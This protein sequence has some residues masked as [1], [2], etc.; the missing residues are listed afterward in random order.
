MP[1][2]YRVLLTRPKADSEA[3]AV[4][5][6]ARGIDSVIA[7]I[8]DIQPT[9]VPLN[10]PPDTQILI[11]TS[12]NAFSVMAG[13]GIDRALPVLAVGVDTAERARAYGF[14]QV[15][16][17]GGT[18]ETLIELVVERFSPTAGPLLW[19]SGEDI[20]VDLVTRLAAYGF[21]I[22]RRIVYR[23]CTARTLP[24]AA[25]NALE[26]NA[27]ESTN[28]NGVL[29]F[30]PR[31]AS[32]FVSLVEKAGLTDRTRHL[33][34]HCLSPTVAEAVSAAVWL[35]IRTALRPRRQDLLAN[36]DGHVSPNAN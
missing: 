11:V 22:V 25:I 35:D 26:V 30:S 34:A 12:G 2:P 7:P 20:R 6:A 29:F 31:T 9:G 18:A 23:A 16:S 4:E 3:L 36:L 13:H 17:V 32:C 14:T 1:R 10:P 27:M 5:L 21:N 24:Q 33:I 28:I 8:L 19:A 15:E